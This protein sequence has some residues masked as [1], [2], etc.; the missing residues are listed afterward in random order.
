MYCPL[1]AVDELKRS[2][3]LRV[4]CSAS[5]ACTRSSVVGPNGALNRFASVRYFHA[6]EYCAS[7][8][9]NAQGAKP[10]ASRQVVLVCFR[11]PL[12]VCVL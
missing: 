6:D 12:V 11:V 7:G 3:W 4:A 10:I 1:E 5:K 2:A 9:L 8:R